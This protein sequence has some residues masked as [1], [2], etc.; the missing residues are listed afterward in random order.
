MTVV[1]VLDVADDAS[2]WQLHGRAL[3]RAGVFPIEEEAREAFRSYWVHGET[4]PTPGDLSRLELAREDRRLLV[5]WTWPNPWGAVA[6]TEDVFDRVRG[7]TRSAGR[8]PGLVWAEEVRLRVAGVMRR[9]NAWEVR[10]GV[11]VLWA[12]S[13]LTKDPATTQERLLSLK[14][15]AEPLVVEWLLDLSHR[16]ML[17]FDERFADRGA[18]AYDAAALRGALDRREAVAGVA[19]A[20][21]KVYRSRSDPSPTRREAAR[22][23][24]DLAP[25]EVHDPRTFHEHLPKPPAANQKYRGLFKHLDELEGGRELTLEELAAPLPLQR[26]AGTR[27]QF[28]PGLPDGARKPQWWANPRPGEHAA[29]AKFPQSRAWLAAGFTAHPQ[30]RGAE[31]RVVAVRFDPLP[32]RDLWWPHRRQLR[33]GTYTP[34]E[35]I[36]A[37]P[38]PRRPA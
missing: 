5:A 33:L 6:T 14:Y 2:L 19:G 31:R 9:L 35:Q 7:R 16:A 10:G 27:G 12:A 1:S 11:G 25:I 20:L 3:R 24:V 22:I 21:S 18:W 13:Q 36:G 34:W 4:R 26:P 15:G 28:A 37:L 32:T 29:L 17:V 38:G 30:T 23:L 8:D